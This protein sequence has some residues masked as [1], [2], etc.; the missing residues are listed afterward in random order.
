MASKRS[1]FDAAVA[2]A[3]FSAGFQGQVSED[4]V[5]RRSDPTTEFRFRSQAGQPLWEMVRIERLM[6]LIAQVV[7]EQN[8]QGKRA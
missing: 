1:V 3:S 5:G 7:V 2:G 6:N 8:P 4:G